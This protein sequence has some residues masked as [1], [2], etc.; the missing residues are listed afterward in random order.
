MDYNFISYINHNFLKLNEHKSMIEKNHKTH[1][2]LL[3]YQCDLKIINNN[4]SFSYNKNQA[5]EKAYFLDG[6]VKPQ[7]TPWS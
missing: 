6:L 1:Q 7:Y 5:L 2:I 3:P 4:F